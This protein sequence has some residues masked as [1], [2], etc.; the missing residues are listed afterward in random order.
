MEVNRT[1]R[2]PGPRVRVR[3]R[4]LVEMAARSRGVHVSEFVRNAAI[5]RA[6]ERLSE[7]ADEGEGEAA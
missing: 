7:L 3:E 2:I 1:A 6:R 4:E 5:E